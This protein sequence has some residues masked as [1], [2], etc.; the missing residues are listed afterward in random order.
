MSAP[1]GIAMVAA[2][3]FPY[4]RGT[5]VRILRQAEGLAARGH[6][7][8]V[9]TYHL[10][11]GPAPAGVSLHRIAPVP[12]YTRVAPGPSVAK[13]LRLDPM[14]RRL[15]AR[16]LGEHRIDVVHAHHYEGLL[17]ARTTRSR[18][19]PLI[20]DAHTLLASE[21]SS[22]V[23]RVPRRL[24]DAAGRLID[25]IAPRL[26]DHTVTVTDQIRERL[27]DGLGYPAG[28]VT[29]VRN[30]VELELFAGTP[31]PPSAPGRPRRLVFAG[32]LAGYQ[33]IDLLLRAFAVAAREEPELRLVIAADDPFE[34]HFPL[35]HSLG[36]GPWIDLVPAPPFDELPAFLAEADICANPRVDCDGMPVKLLNYMAAARPV[37]S[38]RSAAPGVPGEAVRLVTDGDVEAFG[39]AVLALLRDHAAAAALGRQARAHVEAHYRWSDR[40]AELETLYL[41]LLRRGG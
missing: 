37:V 39:A 4:P 33:R 34:P 8:H 9:V 30:G 18:P 28:R 24:V 20:Y 38:F 14:L 16:I 21:L 27:V 26:A 36:L 11:H 31:P 35:A 17:V 19:R 1:L 13:L 41:R 40:A 7:V 6:R 29:T 3:P 5:P 12:S 22:F 23:G 2:C 25:R 10:G 15:L 32:N